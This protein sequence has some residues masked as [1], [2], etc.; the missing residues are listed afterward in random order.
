MEI[1]WFIKHFLRI[2]VF[3]YSLIQWMYAAK[4]KEVS[5]LILSRYVPWLSTE[6]DSMNEVLLTHFIYRMIY[7]CELC[8]CYLEFLLKKLMWLEGEKEFF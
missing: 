5:L 6:G 7:I 4:Y 8:W 1:E 2:A 3:H